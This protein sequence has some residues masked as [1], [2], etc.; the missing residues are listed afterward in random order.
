MDNEKTNQVELTPEQTKLI[1]AIRKNPTKILKITKRTAYFNEDN[2]ERAILSMMNSGLGRKGRR[3]LAKKMMVDWPT[4]LA[5]EDIVVENNLDDLKGPA[6]RAYMH[7][8]GQQLRDKKISK[9]DYRIAWLIVNEGLT[10]EQADETLECL[11]F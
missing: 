3:N 8:K 5:Y 2:H 11:E 10:H 1:A 9:R 4:F 6:L 7:R